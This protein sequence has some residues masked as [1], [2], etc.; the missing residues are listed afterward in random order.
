MISYRR[1]K[2]SDPVAVIACPTDPN[3]IGQG[4]EE[5]QFGFHRC[6]CCSEYPELAGP[7]AI[8]VSIGGDGFKWG[9]CA[10]CVKHMAAVLDD[11]E[12][13]NSGLGNTAKTIYE[14]GD[15]IGIEVE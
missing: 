14:D 5:D 2:R 9:I 15:P 7:V 3:I 6:Y 8:K 10:K 11:G 1:A 4:K 13:K 12:K